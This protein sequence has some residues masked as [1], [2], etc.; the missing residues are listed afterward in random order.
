MR[1]A[2]VKV[3]LPFTIA[4]TSNSTH[5]FRLAV[6]TVLSAAPL[7]TGALFQFIPVSSQGVVVFR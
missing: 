1:R 2:K 3:P 5:V 6:P 7:I 4:L